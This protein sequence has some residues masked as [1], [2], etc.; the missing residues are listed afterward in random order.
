MSTGRSTARSITY[1]KK[2]GHLFCDPPM[3][4]SDVIQFAYEV[5]VTG[6]ATMA[7]ESDDPYEVG[8]GIAEAIAGQLPATVRNVVEEETSHVEED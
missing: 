4:G 1:D 5:L 3:N 7:L 2:S 6:I 8:D